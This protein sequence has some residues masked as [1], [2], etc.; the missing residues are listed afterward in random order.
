MFNLTA[1]WDGH[2]HGRPWQ[3]YLTQQPWR[4]SET[5]EIYLQASLQ[6]P[7]GVNP[8][9]YNPRI[10]SN[11]AQPRDFSEMTNSREIS[12]ILKFGRDSEW[13][14]LLSCVSSLDGMNSLTLTYETSLADCEDTLPWYIAKFNLLIR[15]DKLVRLPAAPRRGITWTR[16]C[17]VEYHTIHIF[18]TEV[19]VSTPEEDGP[20]C[21]IFDAPRAT[22]I[23]RCETFEVAWRA[24]TMCYG[25]EPVIRRSGP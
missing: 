20:P 17:R 2:E 9:A 14:L 21:M 10:P 3:V 19:G 15:E 25:Q 8:E 12:R 5:R 22:F 4:K 11:A 1:P 13:G 23:L 24:I 18:L 16:T 6:Y 7:E